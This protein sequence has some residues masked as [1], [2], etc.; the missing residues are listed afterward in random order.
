[1][2]FNQ[3]KKFTSTRTDYA[4]EDGKVRFIKDESACKSTRF[5]ASIQ[6][7]G[8]A[9][10]AEYGATPKAALGK[11][12]EKIQRLADELHKIAGNCGGEIIFNEKGA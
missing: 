10:I 7:P 3:V 8:A 4:S 5:S 6:I 1:M 11:L 12:K 9:F 2:K